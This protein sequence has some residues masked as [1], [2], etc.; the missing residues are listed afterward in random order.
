MIVKFYGVLADH[1][2]SDQ[3]EIPFQPET[4]S[5]LHYL[6]RHYPGLLVYSFRVAVNNELIE[7]PAELH[8]IDSVALIPPFPGG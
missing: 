2:R 4:E 8:E 6:E 7:M 3:L 5:L 1:V